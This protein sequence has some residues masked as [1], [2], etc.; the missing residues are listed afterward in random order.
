M[1]R[2]VNC[3]VSL[4]DQDVAYMARIDDIHF[5]SF[6]EECGLAVTDVAGTPP[7]LVDRRELFLLS[8]QQRDESYRAL[9]LW[10]SQGKNI[11][12][13]LTLRMLPLQ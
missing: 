12:L 9:P 6:C 2:C 11:Q 10:V 3:K 4:E 1:M 5:I 8:K 13:Q 7:K